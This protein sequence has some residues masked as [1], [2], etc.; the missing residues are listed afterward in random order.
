MKGN[1]YEQVTREMVSSI[2]NDISELKIK[3]DSLETKQDQLF[4]HMSTRL[5]WWATTLIASLTGLCGFLLK[6]VLGGV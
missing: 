3:V 2:R 5:P 1:A 4:N 6:I